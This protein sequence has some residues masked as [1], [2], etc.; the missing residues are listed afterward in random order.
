MAPEYALHG[1]LT[2]KVDVFSFGVLVLEV[3]SGRKSQSL[4]HDT[5]F[6]IQRTWRLYKAERALEVID[7]TLKDSYLWEEG[8]RA[9]KIGLLCIQAAAALRPS[10]SQ[11][12]SMLTSERENLPSPT[13]P[14]FVELDSVVGLHDQVKRPTINATPPQDPNKASSSAATS[15]TRPSDI[16]SGAPSPSSS[17]REPG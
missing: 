3:I 15:S 17:Y 6:L 14:P 7:P 8:I 9:I 12:V 1:Q 5:E 16:Q 10:M 4:V 2:E 13:K 11:V